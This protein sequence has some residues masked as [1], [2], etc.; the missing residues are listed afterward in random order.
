MIAVALIAVVFGA[1]Q[2][3]M[4]LY[5]AIIAGLLGLMLGL[6]IV[7]HKS[8]WPAVF[9]HGFIDATSFAILPFVIDRLHGP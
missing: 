5:A 7:W 6:I 4:G 3:N 9:A 1:A 2:I 8:I